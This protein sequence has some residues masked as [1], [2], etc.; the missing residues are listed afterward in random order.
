MS[1][2][3]VDVLCTGVT[4][5]AFIIMLSYV[6]LYTDI[7]HSHMLKITFTTGARGTKTG[8]ILK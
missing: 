8:K 1:T 3:I 6:Y 5:Q 2:L 7:L 4:Q